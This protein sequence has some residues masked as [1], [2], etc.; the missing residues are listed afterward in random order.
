KSTATSSAPVATPPPQW[1]PVAN[2][3]LNP[4]RAT[5]AKLPDPVNKPAKKTED[6]KVASNQDSDHHEAAAQTDSDPALAS[7]DGFYLGA[8]AFIQFAGMN[9][10]QDAIIIGR[11][12]NAKY[13]QK[14]GTTIVLSKPPSAAN[15]A[16]V[17]TAAEAATAKPDSIAAV[18]QNPPTGITL[19]DLVHS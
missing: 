17:A 14:G 3:I 10:A 1:N 7:S 15:T 16:G 4:Q 6:V 19:G 12:G 5:P 11:G 18:S 13:V 9:V 2:A 8:G